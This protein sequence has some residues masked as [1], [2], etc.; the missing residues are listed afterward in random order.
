[1]SRRRHAAFQ[2]PRSGR[3]LA[4]GDLDGD[5]LVDIV[6]S[7]NNDTPS[8]LRNATAS[9]GKW[10]GVRLE[11]SGSNRDGYGSEVIV[12]TDLGRRMEH[13]PIPPEAICRR[14]RRCCISD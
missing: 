14:V 2:K 4:T 7:N 6:I 12:T 13:M 11:G 3:G 9:A 5:G 8:V 1:M 10:I